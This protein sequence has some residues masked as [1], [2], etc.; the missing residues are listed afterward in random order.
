[1]STGSAFPRRRFRLGNC[2]TAPRTSGFRLAPKISDFGFL[3]VAK[4]FL[5]LLFWLPSIQTPFLLNNPKIGRTGA[6]RM[7][8]G[9]RA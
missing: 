9:V 2:V 8:A 5:R 6:A 1:M 3:D 7:W 4:W